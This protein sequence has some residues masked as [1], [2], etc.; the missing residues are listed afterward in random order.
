M[1]TTGPLANL[2]GGTV[3]LKK[4]QAVSLA[5]A[6]APPLAKV[7]VALGWSPATSG[8]DI[9]LDASVIAYGGPRR[10]GLFGGG[11]MSHKSTVYFGDKS[12]YRGAISHGGD[13]LTGH[14]TSG[15]TDKETIDIDLSAL[16]DEVTALAV[17]INSYRGHRFNAVKD[18]FC[19]LV[20]R[21]TGAEL[22]RYDL[23]GSQ[24]STGVIMATLTRQSPGGTWTMRAVGEFKDGRTARDMERP[25]ADIL[26]RT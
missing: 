9:D 2:D 1:V 14:G 10:S 6:G 16:P 20:N 15:Q 7:R 19:R 3:S 11:G 13:N 24:A 8:S 25:A 23:S 26:A 21:D 12:A 5:K 22:V 18:A 4:G 17:T